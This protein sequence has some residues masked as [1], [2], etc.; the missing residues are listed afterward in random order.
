MF[1]RDV[2]IDSV[3]LLL[4]VAAAVLLAG[5]IKRAAGICKIRRF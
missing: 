5:R 3:G 4:G 1:A 2:L